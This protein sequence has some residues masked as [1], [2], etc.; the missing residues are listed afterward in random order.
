MNYQLDEIAWQS[1]EGDE[2]ICLTLT[3]DN[4]VF[5]A[6]QYFDPESGWGTDETMEFGTDQLVSIYELIK[7]RI[8]EASEPRFC[9]GT[10]VEI[11][12]LM[13]GVA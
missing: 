5:I 1:T 7:S 3:H 12:G 2:R 6:R 11:S 4:E 8:A 13:E 9:G 10:S